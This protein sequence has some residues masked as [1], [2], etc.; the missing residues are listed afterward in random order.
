M[1]FRCFELQKQRGMILKQRV[2]GEVLPPM[3]IEALQNA[4]RSFKSATWSGSEWVPPKK[5]TLDPIEDGRQM[6]IDDGGAVR[7]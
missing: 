6:I 5:L 4:A 2:Q 7:V 3:R 1:N